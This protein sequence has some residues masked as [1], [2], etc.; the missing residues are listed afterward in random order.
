MKNLA[1]ILFSIIVLFS[2]STERSSAQF[3]ETGRGRSSTKW[4]QIDSSNYKIVFPKGYELPAQ[5]ISTLLDS[6][7]PYITYSLDFPIQKVPIILHTDNLFSNGY[8]TWAPKRAELVMSPLGD[9]YAL[10][11][12]KQLA[13]HEWRHVAQISTLRQGLTKIASWLLGEAGVSAGLAVTPRWVLEGDAVLAETQF[14][15]YGRGLQPSFTIGYRALLADGYTNFNRLDPWICGS[16]NRQYPDIYKFGY[17]TLSAAETYLGGDYFGK[18]M[19]YSGKYPILL[20]P[21][22]IFL[23]HNY[24][25]TFKG[26]AK[27]AFSELD[28]LWQ[29][30]YN[31]EENF[32]YITSPD[33]K[34]YTVYSYPVQFKD[35]VLAVEVSFNNPQKIVDI[36]NN[37]RVKSV[38]YISSPLVVKGDKIYYTEYLYHPIFEQV[39]FSAIKE[40]DPKTK[41][42]KTYHRWGVNYSLTSCGNEGFA[43]LTLDSLSRVQVRTFDSKFN[44]LEQYYISDKECSASSLT[45]DSQTQ[46]LYFIAIDERGNYIGS[47][48]L[49]GELQEVT[50][51][52]LR[53]M[54][55]LRANGGMLYFSSIE[56]GKDEVHSLNLATNEENQLTESK[57][58]TFM[59]SV[60][61]DSLLITSY[62]SSGYMLSSLP[63]NSP[64]I[65]S[66]EWSRLPQ[67][68]LNPKR[69]EWNV[70]KIDTIKSAANF[71]AVAPDSLTTPTT[72]TAKEQRKLERENRFKAPFA[73]HSWAPVAF[74]GDY[75][76]ES[77]A[78]SL[79]LGVTTFFQSTLSKFNG[80]AT[81][82]YLNESFWA[83]GRVEYQGLPLNI[84]LGVEYGGGMQSVL[85]ESDSYKSSESYELKPYLNSDIT[86]SLPLN[87][88]SSGYSKLLQPSFRLNY[89]NARVLDSQTD[90]YQSGLLQY[91]GSLWWSSSRNLAHRNLNP[92]LG[93]AIRADIMGGFSSDFGRIYSLYTIGYFPGIF[94]NHSTTL[95][96]ST[97]YQESST[98][99]FSSKGLY[100]TGVNDNYATTSYSAASL[101]YS[102]PLAYPD[103]GIEGFVFIKRIQASL[104]GGYSYG[105]YLTSNGTTIGLNNYSY[106]VDLIVDFSLLRAYDHGMTFSF[107]MPNNEFYFSVGYSL[108]F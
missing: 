23:K 13:L 14:A 9:S 22:D 16:Y 61:G 36:T 79:A 34:N 51:P 5:S 10:L 50:K 63:L 57:F 58:G 20:M 38:G 93:Y 26:I 24:Q 21:Q 41:R 69:L 67:N 8:V 47:I 59:G 46:K 75:L 82:G 72:L 95:K 45:W 88:S 94:K 104:Y 108:N 29:K 91:T 35:R 73:I 66:V 33:P 76:M 62:T 54:S 12:S 98:Y 30:S 17:Q 96:L 11:W 64:T 1:L 39:S 74:D 25:T 56:S 53:S 85:G 3:Y 87:L 99:N 60:S 48:T 32:S 103:W 28:S 92:K 49:D 83:K 52:N 40:F 18:M 44:I 102:L 106:G 90:S 107:M 86:L 55:D 7:H 80:Y 97:Q 70:P 6:V 4:Q 43:T 84:S 2:I 19:S 15:E 31:V 71:A 101:N 27:R 105:N 65:R 81:A 42:I 100:L 77:R 68:R 37:R 89:S 78:M